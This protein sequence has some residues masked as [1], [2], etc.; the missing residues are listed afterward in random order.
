MKIPVKYTDFRSGVVRSEELQELIIT[1]KIMSFRR[2]DDE[3]VK[4]G[5]DPIRGMGG[6]YRGP[7]RR[8][9]VQFY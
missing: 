3:W 4:I 1:R 8:G 5:V 7:E 6:R 2:D 9:N